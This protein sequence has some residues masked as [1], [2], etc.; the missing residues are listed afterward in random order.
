MFHHEAGIPHA[1]LAPH[2]LEVALPALAVR[3][4][5]KHEIKLAPGECVPGQRGAVLDVVRLGALPLQNQVSL[6]DGVRLRV[7]LLAVKMN[8]NL[9]ALV[10]G[11]PRK[12][13]LRHRQHAARAA[14]A[15][16]DK[17]GG[18][19]HP[20]RDRLEDKMR[21][22][23]HHVPRRE[24]LARLLVVL[25]AEAPDQLLKNRAHAVVVQAGH[26]HAA[27]R[28]EHRPR[29]EVDR[30]VQELFDQKTENIIVYQPRNLV[31]EP[32]FFQNLL[33]IGREP[34]EV[35]FEVGAQLLLLPDGAKVTQSERGCVVEGLPRS[36][37][38]RPVLVGDARLVQLRLHALHRLLGRFQHRVQAAH[39]GH[40]Q[41]DIAVLAAH[42]V[43]AQH[44]VGNAPDKIADVE[45]AHALAFLCSSRP[46]ASAAGWIRLALQY[47]SI[48]AGRTQPAVVQAVVH[49]C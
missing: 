24:M 10:A 23:L 42:I 31:A 18:R 4:V 3:R 6:A 38:Q 45:T 33:H 21:H 13:I 19:L 1:R 8:R 44:V 9:L 43:V 32:E 36:L 47:H 46:L 17:I 22:Q 15:V 34:V 39:D 20:V 41:N 30:T 12:R 48:S 37:P 27:V 49:R 11:E 28:V 29:T 5:G 7:D 26:A 16:I 14:G 35:G 40:G 2:P 25:L